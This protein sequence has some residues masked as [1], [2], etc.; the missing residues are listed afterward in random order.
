MKMV[1][2]LSM[3]EK[4]KVDCPHLQS[5]IT[6]PFQRQ[7]EE[8]IT[9]VSKA[10][11]TTSKFHSLYLLNDVDSPQFTFLGC[12]LEK[13]MESELLKVTDL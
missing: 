10:H 5:L 8:K 9:F 2:V 1:L 7:L 6:P 12:S 3:L 11:A 4:E 13:K